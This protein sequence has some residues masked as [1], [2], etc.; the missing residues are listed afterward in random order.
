MFKAR[1]RLA[2][3]RYRLTI[4]FSF[5]LVAALSTFLLSTF[6][7][8]KLSTQ[9]YRA[10]EE[11]S[12]FL[13]G[14]TA[15][16]IHRTLSG[17][18]SSYAEF[19]ATN[20]FLQNFRNAGL[21]QPYVKNLQHVLNNKI[22]R[23]G[24]VDSIYLLDLDNP[25]M[26]SSKDGLV[27]R[28]TFYDSD[29]FGF[30]NEYLRGL[31]DPAETAKA[32]GSSGQ[33]NSSENAQMSAFHLRQG[34]IRKGDSR[35]MLSLAFSDPTYRKRM[36]IVNLDL[37]LAFKEFDPQSLEHQLFFVSR[38][39][40]DIIAANAA[41]LEAH[42]LALGSIWPGPQ[43]V[44]LPN[45]KE[46]AIENSERISY[47]S[48]LLQAAN[49]KGKAA[50]F[51]RSSAVIM[52]LNKHEYVWRSAAQKDLPFDLH[53]LL[54]ENSIE[55]NLETY[56]QPLLILF[57]A[58]III[59]LLLALLLTRLIY[60]PLGRLISN[61]S[62][63]V[64]PTQRTTATAPSSQDGKPLD[65]FAYLNSL[66]Q[67]LSRENRKAR[68]NALFS[69]KASLA[70]MNLDE[71]RD[72]AFSNG[73]DTS[74]FV[75]QYDEGSPVPE[76]L[77]EAQTICTNMGRHELAGLLNG[78]EKS[79]L[80][81]LYRQRSE[82]GEILYI[83]QAAL[84][85]DF[86]KAYKRAAVACRLAQTEDRREIQNY[87]DLQPK[88]SNVNKRREVVQKAHDYLLAHAFDADFS[89]DELA[90][91]AGV[92]LG[93]LRTLYKDEMGHTINEIIAQRR[94]DEACRLLRETKLSAKE[95]AERV[96][97]Y[98][99]RYFYTSFKKAVGMTTEAYRRG[100]AEQSNAEGGTQ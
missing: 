98:D 24:W 20:D 72:F 51:Q 3:G 35:P 12:D 30:I 58:A 95:I 73:P 85:N 83:G 71:Q 45:A 66:Y 26:I 28:N 43:A 60:Q 32:N 44:D 62:A 46:E 1:M 56:R 16:G 96:G 97:F 47:S 34:A 65:E 42:R 13:L 59:N 40:D 52:D 14:Q 75:L 5:I 80:V 77:E 2:K 87:D 84:E 25:Y 38:E 22:I 18:Y 86:A 49:H 8:Q 63:E 74:C 90:A 94:M 39:N 53:M 41:F 69:G 79:R 23:F 68:L 57:I 82:A 67:N 91:A 93:Y 27:S 7:S 64:D 37:A 78:P 99:P 6:I 48:Q 9:I 15:T 81:E 89:N 54:D 19:W 29:V 4:L 17:I 92:S 76:L 33:P 55:R 88:A 36:L 11:Q 21:E 61:V 31:Q 70:E 100:A 10:A 50:L